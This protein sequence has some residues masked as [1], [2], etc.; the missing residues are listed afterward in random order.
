M[1]A[2]FVFDNF[3]KN[4]PSPPSDMVKVFPE[5]KVVLMSATIDTSIFSEYFGSC[6]I[7]EVYGR[8]H[9][10]QEYF[11]ED[12]IQ[13]TN[14]VAPPPRKKGKNSNKDNDSGNLSVSVL[15]IC[16]HGTNVTR[17]QTPFRHC[18]YCYFPNGKFPIPLFSLRATDD[19]MPDFNDD[20]ALNENLNKVCAPDYQENTKRQMGLLSE[21]DISFELVEN[22]LKYIKSEWNLLIGYDCF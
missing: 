18:L 14:F 5:M 7:I 8:T 22:L 19:E 21:K 3:K 15:I 13:M 17:D 2:G 20:P 16:I 1:L 9:P 12:C 10:I 4:V 6:P 11:L